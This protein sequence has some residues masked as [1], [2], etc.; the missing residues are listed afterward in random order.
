MFS[1]S[2]LNLPWNIFDTIISM[3]E[4]LVVCIPAITVFMYYKVQSLSI[5]PLDITD[6]GTTLLIHNKTNKS[7]FITDM[8]FVASEESHFVKP[9][10][11][12]NSIVTQ[13]KP[14]D[15]LEVTINYNKT[16]QDKQSFKVVVKFNQRKKKL[17]VIV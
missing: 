3:I 7:I 16:S 11:A 8:Q 9:C 1:E 14:D 13:L 15:Y 17:K 12:W 6:N 5:W 10:I 2:F 4:L